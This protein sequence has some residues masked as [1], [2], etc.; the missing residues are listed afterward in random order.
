MARKRG[1]R[2]RRG[3]M[4]SGGSLAGMLLGWTGTGLVVAQSPGNLGDTQEM[5]S[6]SETVSAQRLYFNK[7]TIHLPIQ[8]SDQYRAQVK[9]SSYFVHERTSH[10]PVDA[11]G[12]PWGR[13]RGSFSF[14]SQHDGEICVY[15]G[16]GR[17]RPADA[18]PADINHEPAGLVIIIRHAAAPGGTGKPSTWERKRR[19]SS[20]NLW[21]A[22][23]TSTVPRCDSPS[24]EEISN[25]ASSNRW[26]IGRAFSVCRNRQFSLVSCVRQHR[27]S[28]GT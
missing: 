19:G 21:L 13:T 18:S 3:L 5:G 28:A 7:N 11:A 15:H 22:T 8:I 9:G 20:S 24:R 6:A 2:M 17:A 27:T 10:V 1:Q 25:F 23:A 4:L 12:M 14:H 26:R 16:H